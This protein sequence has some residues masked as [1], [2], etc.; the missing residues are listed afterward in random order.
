MSDIELKRDTML[1]DIVAA[2]IITAGLFVI[3]LGIF[4]SALESDLSTI[5]VAEC[6]D[7]Y[8]VTT[9]EVLQCPTTK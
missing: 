1:P 9:K 4:E 6:H 3:S 8:Q 5:G 2:L 7:Q